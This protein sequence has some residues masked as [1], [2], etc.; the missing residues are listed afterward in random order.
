[1]EIGRY[2]SM[3]EWIREGKF[4]RMLGRRRKKKKVGNGTYVVR[5]WYVVVTEMVQRKKK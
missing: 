1:M 3:S 5:E 2:S 4:E